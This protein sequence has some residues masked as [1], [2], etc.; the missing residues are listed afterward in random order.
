V[1]NRRGVRAVAINSDGIVTDLVRPSGAG[2]AELTKATG[3]QAHSVR[4]VMS[5]VLKRKLGSTIESDK[6]VKGQR[7]YRLAE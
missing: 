5:G 2:L 6:N 7:R 4:G 3:W 1:Q